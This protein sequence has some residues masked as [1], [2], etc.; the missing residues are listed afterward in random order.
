MGYAKVNPQA[1]RTSLDPGRGKEPGLTSNGPPSQAYEKNSYSLFSK[2]STLDSTHTPVDVRLG[3]PM[4]PKDL[5]H[6]KQSDN[7]TLE[8]WENAIPIASTPAHCI[9]RSMCKTFFPPI[10]LSSFT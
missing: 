4:P 5:P 8:P 10:C 1:L 9:L 6:R 7:L 3:P 2:H